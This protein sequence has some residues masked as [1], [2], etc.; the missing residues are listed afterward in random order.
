MPA[1]FTASF[2]KRLDG[3]CALHVVEVDRLI[4]LTAGHVFI[5]RGDADVV[6]ERRLGRILVNSV[7]AAESL[8]HPSVDRLVRTAM[9]ALP[10]ASLTGVQLTGMG[11]D[12][13]E[14][15]AALKAGGGRTIAESEAT[16]AVFGMPAE[17]IRRGGATA[18]L[19]C[20]RIAERLIAWA[21]RVP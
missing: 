16:A 5:G 20:D 14:A 18:V 3:I 19:P 13:A 6:I 1:G 9:E 12:G 2:A 8:W 10:A 15:M 7:K 11:D 21:G 4:P 17:L